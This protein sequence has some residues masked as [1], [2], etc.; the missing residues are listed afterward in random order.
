M[1]VLPVRLEPRPGALEERLAA[2]LL[3][4]RALGDQLLLDHVLGRDAGVVVAGLPERVEAAHPV[5]ADQAVLHR[6][7]ERVADVQL[8]G[9][10]RRRDADHVGG[11]AGGR[12]GAGP[13]EAL[14]LPALAASA[15]RRRGG[16]SACPSSE[17]S[18]FSAGARPGR[19]RGQRQVSSGRNYASQCRARGASLPLGRLFGE[20]GGR[21]APRPR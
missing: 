4:R 10:V 8:A 9:H 19:T 6:P 2:D 15:P 16:R 13:V 3:A 20:L 17:P 18:L 14:V 5:P 1:I 11:V 21:P 7:V 12:A